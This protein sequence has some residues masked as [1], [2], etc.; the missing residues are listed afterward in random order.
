MEGMKSTLINLENVFFKYPMSENWIL[1]NVNLTLYQG[2][3]IGIVGDNGSGKST[4]S[5]LILGIEKPNKGK[6]HY[7]QK[8][9]RWNKHY[10]QIGYIGDPSHS[11]E[12]Q[13][14]PSNLSIKKLVQMLKTVYQDSI[15]LSKLEELCTSLE[16]DKLLDKETQ[17]LSTGERKRIMA[18]LALSK[19]NEVLILDEPFDGLDQSV[20]NTLFEL[21]QNY[22]TPAISVLYIAHNRIEIDLF[23]DKVHRIFN[24]NLSKEE[25]REF[26]VTTHIDNKQIS[27]KN[28]KLGLL[29][30]NLIKLL[31][32]DN[33]NSQVKLE[34]HP[35][36]RKPTNNA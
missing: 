5:K 18:L 4:I 9:V 32:S 31:E 36:S 10:P 21:L 1:E 26:T 17:N 29:Q 34:I 27:S 35:V 3:K 19:P 11:A 16:V 8:P 14:L 7:K 15:G 25:Q 2:D 6:I 13:G 23:T 12:M 24:R 30:Y 20:K 33:L 28:E 22:L